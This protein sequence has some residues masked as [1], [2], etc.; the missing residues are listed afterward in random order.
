MSA[1]YEDEAGIHQMMH[2]SRYRCE[3]GWCG[4]VCGVWLPLRQLVLVICA[5]S[6]NQIWPPTH[7][8][9]LPFLVF[10]TIIQFCEKDPNDEFLHTTN[11]YLL[12]L[13]LSLNS[14]YSSITLAALSTNPMSVAYNLQP[15]Q[16]TDRQTD[17]QIYSCECVFSP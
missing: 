12:P 14:I 5:F 16:Y 11:M 4:V 2:V 17:T 7:S 1:N 8:F 6:P 15:C 3:C 13:E 9:P 10:F